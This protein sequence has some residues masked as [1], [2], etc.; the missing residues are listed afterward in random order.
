M[1]EQIKSLEKGSAVSGLQVSG[2]T[3]TRTF[4][5]VSF[6][7]YVNVKLLCCLLKKLSWEKSLK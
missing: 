2:F 1:L 3:A 7:F 5:E 4:A 6:N